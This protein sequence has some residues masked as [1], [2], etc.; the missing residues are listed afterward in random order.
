[1]SRESPKTRANYE[2]QFMTFKL[3]V[4]ATPALLMVFFSAQAEGPVATP[5]EVDACRAC[6]GPAGISLNPTIPNLAGQK[7][8]YLET[9]L[10][11]FRSKDRK[12][13]FMNVIAA[14]LNDTNIHDL[15]VYWSSRSAKPN[16]EASG[17]V[18]ASS[19]IHSRM[20]FPLAFPAGFTLYQTEVEEG[21]MTRRY[22]NAVATTA[23]RAGKKLPDGSVILQVSYKARKDAAGKDIAGP[24]QSYA[25]MESR[26]D[27]G[28]DIPL[29]LRN[30]NWDYAL[31]AAD[32]K[33]HDQLN[34]AQCLACHK[35]K[36]SDSYVFTIMQLRQAPSS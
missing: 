7:P 15:A 17:D 27:W 31:F 4:L 12:N 36:E 28:K 1:V 24:V 16:S 32:A 20:R 23:A 26:S 25:G 11:A 19:A 8:A 21:T 2:K 3:R 35:P 30:E 18:P 5:V 14:Q 29:L 13:D 22:A 33:R 34:E 10:K 9:Q 6:H